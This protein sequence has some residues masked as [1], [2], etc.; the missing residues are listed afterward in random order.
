MVPVPPLFI[1]HAQNAGA[2]HTA[3]MSDFAEFRAKGREA[4]LSGRATYDSPMADGSPR[5][6]AAAVLR[7]EGEVVARMTDL[8]AT[9]DAPGHRVHGGRTLHVTIRSL[10][11]YRTVIPVDDPLRRAYGAALAEAAEDLPPAR[12]YFAGVSPH[13]GGVLVGVHPLDETLDTL[14]KRFAGALDSRGVR[15]LDHGRVRDLWYVSLLHFAAPVTDAGR[16]VEWC[17]AHA[18]ADFGTAELPTAEIVQFVLTG[19]TVRVDSLEQV[20]LGTA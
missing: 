6:G 11:P 16:I 17:D 4:L 15:D 12:A 3:R 1:C 18:G 9:L 7:P 10:E 13:P 5:W 2:W 14:R 20:T 19:T 8:A